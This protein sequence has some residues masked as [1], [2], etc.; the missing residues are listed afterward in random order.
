M[1]SKNIFMDVECVQEN[2]KGQSTC[3][4]VFLSRKIQDEDRLVATL[5]DGLGSG[6]KANVLAMLTASM[7]V[8]FMLAHEPIERTSKIIMDTLPVCE[9][10]KISYS[11][12]TI[13]DVAC[14]GETNIIEYDN[15]RVIIIRDNKRFTPEAK[16]I[17]LKEGKQ[18][19]KTILAT[20]FNVEKEDRIIVLSDGITQSGIGSKAMPFGWGEDAVTSHICNIIKKNPNVSARMLAQ[21][22]VKE[23]SINDKFSAKDDSSCVVIY[24]REPRK[25]LLCSGPPFRETLDQKVA[26]RFDR[27][28]GKKVICGGTTAE[29][30]SRE[31]RRE[32]EVQLI[33]DS[34]GLPPTS[35]MK[36]ADLI[37]EGIITIGK[38]A[39]ILENINSTQISGEGPAIEIVN[40]FFDSDEIHFI[41][42][43]K[44]NEAHQDPSLPVELEIR[45]NVFK[46]IVK[47]LQEKFLK[48]VHLEF[49]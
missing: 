32:I 30:L 1:R 12:F 38:V 48:E 10:R 8:N 14:D 33:I 27:F 18:A 24:F 31:L 15:P 28:K 13:V 37:S 34:S 16:E 21:N 41:I 2:K 22:I 29:I 11:T 17:T 6:V 35:K 46:K 4:D 19:G 5:S 25:M 43:T 49:I 39:E 45:R 44:I 42:G 40:M 3:G 23:A 26:L 47:L 7:S 9:V 20:T 36:G